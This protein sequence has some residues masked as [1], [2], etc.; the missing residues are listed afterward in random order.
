VQLYD[1]SIVDFI[2]ADYTILD[3]IDNDLPAK[4]VP[5]YKVSI[6]TGLSYNQ[7]RIGVNLI[8]EGERDDQNSTMSAYSYTNVSLHYH[9]DSS[10]TMFAIIN[11]LFDKDYETAAGYNE[12]E[13]TVFIGLKK[14]F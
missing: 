3:A 1:W 11:N 8:S 13:R 7:W 10:T 2:R 14:Q 12:P 9:Y 6:A 5:D 4:K